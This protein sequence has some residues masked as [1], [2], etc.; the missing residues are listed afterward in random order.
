[1]IQEFKN[2][3][4]SDEI[5]DILQ[6]Y[7]WKKFSRSKDHFV[8][9][10]N[11]EIA[12]Y[13]L[14]ISY[15]KERLYFDCILDMEFPEKRIDDLYVLINYLNEKSDDGYFI[16]D[17]ENKLIKYKNSIFFPNNLSNKYLYDLIDTICCDLND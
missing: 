9:N 13:Y 10:R 11:G 6:K 7:N 16:F 4:V 8:F 12:D 1:M 2:T 17:I 15:K 14:N 3:I 5:Y